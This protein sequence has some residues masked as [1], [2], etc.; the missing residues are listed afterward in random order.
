M[1][2]QNAFVFSPEINSNAIA[3]ETIDYDFPDNLKKWNGIA[4]VG[5]A[6]GAEEVRLK[7]PFVGRSGQLLDK[8]LERAK[9][10]RRQCLVAN[11]FR[12]QPPGNKVDHFFISR[13][14][15]KES[16]LPIDESLGQFGSLWCRLNF[17][18]EIAHLSATLKKVKPKIIV[19]LGRTPLW[20]LTGMNGLLDKVGTPLSCRLMPSVFVIPTYHPSFILRGNWGLQDKWL[21]HFSQAKDYPL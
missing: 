2:T 9:I 20:A 11:V 15:S 14:A 8:I 1:A 13:R 7:H 19:A 5:E 18:S 12:Q 16:N 4:L 17:A 10:D 21:E 6:P 3:S